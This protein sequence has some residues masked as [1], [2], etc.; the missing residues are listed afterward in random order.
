M[1]DMDNFTNAGLRRILKKNADGAIVTKGALEEF[2]RAVEY[3]ADVL[4]Q[5]SYAAAK[6]ADRKSIQT[7]DVLFAVDQL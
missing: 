4:A 5:E 7:K 6:H 3:Y 1:V 2:R